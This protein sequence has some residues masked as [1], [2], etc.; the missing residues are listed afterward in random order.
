MLEATTSSAGGQGQTIYQNA[1]ALRMPRVGEIVLFTPNPGDTTA[2]SNYNDSEI[3]AIVTRVW[4]HGCVNLKIIPDCG[5][6]QD[7]TS[8]VHWSLNGA[9]YNF[10]FSDEQVECPTRL[11][12]HPGD[13]ADASGFLKQ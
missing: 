8:V 9:G 10:R 12:E 6:M 13:G 1:S 2:K 4:S 11:T 3:A 5:P 7:R